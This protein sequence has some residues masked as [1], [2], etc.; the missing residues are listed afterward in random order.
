MMEQVKP[1]RCAFINFPLGHQCGRPND[2]ALQRS[3]LKDALNILE[4]ASTPGEIVDLT[5]EWGAPFDWPG[6]MQDLMQM[7]EEE[8]S[9]VQDWKPKE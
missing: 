8:G 1:P 4:S 2:G 7:L 3:I 5:Y 6:F 9:P